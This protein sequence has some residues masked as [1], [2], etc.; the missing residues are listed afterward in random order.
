MRPKHAATVWRW[1]LAAPGNPALS[2]SDLMTIVA[3]PENDTGRFGSVT[4]PR[5][6][7][8]TQHG[9]AGRP[10]AFRCL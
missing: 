6:G 7:P 8:F 1:L 4:S 2:K 9:A 3:E 10:M 5:C